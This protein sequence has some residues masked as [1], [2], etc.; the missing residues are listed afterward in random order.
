MRM[1]RRKTMFSYLSAL[2]FKSFCLQFTLSLIC[3][4]QSPLL[5][6]LDHIFHRLLDSSGSV[7]TWLDSFYYTGHWI[8]P[9]TRLGISALPHFDCTFRLPCTCISYFTGRIRHA[10]L[11]IFCM[12]EIRKLKISLHQHFTNDSFNSQHMVFILPHIYKILRMTYR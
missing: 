1:D 3:S 2:P 5:R 11:P 4:T 10:M 8:N 9:K 12:W 6:I 7:P